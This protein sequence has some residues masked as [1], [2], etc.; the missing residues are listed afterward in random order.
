MNV[1]EVS[2]ETLHALPFICGPINNNTYAFFDE[3]SKD[4]VVIDP[5]FYFDRVL[6]KILELGYTPREYW[7]THAHYDHILGTAYPESKKMNIT[8]HLHS[9]DEILF[10]EAVQTKGSMFPLIAG[11][12][13]PLMDLD[14]GKELHVGKF[15]FQTLFTP[16]HAPG[17]CCFYCEQ[18]G[19]L[20]SGDLIFY[21]SYG[22]TDLTGG[23]EKTLFKSIYE[24]VLTLPQETLIMP[25]HEYFTRVRNEKV[26]YS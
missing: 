20:F 23:D 24:K 8:A 3:E 2:F 13:R 4:C 12:P 10:D 25:G 18:A 21:H 26:F 11:C 1:S 22:R 16:G 19:W 14:D 17:H 9:K 15:T 7:L 6:Q 5:S